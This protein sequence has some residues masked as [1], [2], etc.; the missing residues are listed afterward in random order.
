MHPPNRE[1][2]SVVHYIQMWEFQDS[3]AKPNF[4]KACSLSFAN[5]DPISWRVEADRTWIRVEL[6]GEGREGWE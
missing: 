5:L 2:T 6:S 1:Y 4:K 3:T